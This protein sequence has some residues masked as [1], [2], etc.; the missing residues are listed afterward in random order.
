MAESVVSAAQQTIGSVGTLAA[1]SLQ[2][3]GERV[4]DNLIDLVASSAGFSYAGFFYVLG[5]LTAFFLVAIGG[6]YKHWQWFIV[7]PPLFY[8]LLFYR[9]EA[10]QPAW[11]FGT[12]S[13]DSTQGDIA[14]KKVTTNDDKVMLPWAYARWVGLTSSLSQTLVAGINFVSGDV[15]NDLDFL[16]KGR[17]YASLFN[18]RIRNQDL[19]RFVRVVAFEPCL[20][21]MQLSI[22]KYTPP[23]FYHSEQIDPQLEEAGRQVAVS[24]SD[25]ERYNLLKKLL[26]GKFFGDVA[27]KETYTCKELWGLALSAAERHAS[28]LIDEMASSGLGPQEDKERAK[29]MMAAKFGG[30]CPAE[31]QD[32]GCTERKVVSMTRAAAIHMLRS[33]LNGNTPNTAMLSVP[34][35][36]RSKEHGAYLNTNRIL[37]SYNFAYEFEAKGRVLG[38]S[39]VMP[40]LE[41]VIRFFLAVTYIFPCFMVLVPS[42]AIGSMFLWACLTLWV[43]LFQPAY[44]VVMLVDRVLY[45]LLP[46]GPLVSD[47]MA[48]N[49][50][51]AF[52]II[53]SVD[54]SASVTTANQIVGYLI[55]AIPM[56][57]GMPFHRRAGFV[58]SAAASRLGQVGKIAEMVGGYERS[59][60]TQGG[61]G[62]ANMV[63][64][65]AVYIY[66]AQALASGRFPLLT[67]FISPATKA[68]ITNAA[69]SANSAMTSGAANQAAAFSAAGQ[70]SKAA[71]TEFFTKGMAETASKLATIGGGVAGAKMQQELE[72]QLRDFKTGMNNTLIYTMQS[73]GIGTLN[74]DLATVGWEQHGSLGYGNAEANVASEIGGYMTFL[75]GPV[76]QWK[77]DVREGMLGTARGSRK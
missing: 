54:P 32:P 45:N 14:A 25:P 12:R 21:Y 66:A 41:G 55:L 42:R 8:F 67:G 26:S 20:R 13:Y 46:R 62:K 60:F 36:L 38:Y 6:S 28:D 3:A 71:L 37:N 50:G 48:S 29:K 30:P 39:M 1:H 75:E 2:W 11:Q 70:V 10:S 15:G 59:R 17:K 53:S 69:N 31:D 49:P 33:E 74:E 56:L 34:D 63:A 4:L 18:M 27:L 16:K 77:A 52:S 57:V 35:Q 9:I 5:A 65:N 24:P 7:G 58:I 23:Q 40:Y 43:S 47:E 73:L 22:S 51:D 61:L 44:A 72:M 19:D 68:V 64:N 76:S